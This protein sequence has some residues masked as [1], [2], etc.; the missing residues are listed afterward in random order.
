MA[1]PGNRPVPSSFRK[2][3]AARERLTGTFVKTLSI[4]AKSKPRPPRISMACG[5][6]EHAPFNP[7]VSSDQ[8]FLREVARRAPVQMAQ[9]GH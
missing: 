4:T 1:E 9:P 5:V 2:R 3:F 6:E 8:G 7:E